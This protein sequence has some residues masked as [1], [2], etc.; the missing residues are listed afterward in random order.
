MINGEQFNEKG[1]VFYSQWQ[2]QLMHRTGSGWHF[3]YMESD[4]YT[5]LSTILLIY[6]MLST[7]STTQEYQ[8]YYTLTN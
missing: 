3:W 6:T 1:A 5:M 4:N 8:L 2:D 7:I